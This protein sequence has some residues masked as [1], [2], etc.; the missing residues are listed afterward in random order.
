[1]SSAASQPSPD[2][3]VCER[4]GGGHSAGVTAS[5]IIFCVGA[6]GDQLLRRGFL[7]IGCWL[8]ARWQGGI[9]QHAQAQSQFSTGRLDL[10]PVAALYSC[11]SIKYFPEVLKYCIA[12]WLNMD[13]KYISKLSPTV[14]FCAGM[15]LVV[16]GEYNNQF[17]GVTLTDDLFL[18]SCAKTELNCAC[19]CVCVSMS[20]VKNSGQR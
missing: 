8:D 10:S 4:K 18:G 14:D 5:A 15:Y 6:P 2:K 13:S 9:R 16:I 12:G 1:M 17:P 20:S 19:V 7:C 3:C 11:F